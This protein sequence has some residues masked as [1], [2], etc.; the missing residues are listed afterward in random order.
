[1]PKI[2]LKQAAVDK[3]SCPMNKSKAD[4]FDTK[5]PGL[6]LKTLSS[7]KKT[8]YLRYRDIH[9]KTTERKIADA[10]VIKLADARELAQK[11]LTQIAMGEDPFKA[12][13]LL[14]DVPTVREFVEQSYMPYI[15]SYKRS[16]TT[17]W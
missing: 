10:T 6:L 9:N 1:L 12:Q 11:K 7:G 13:K 5:M 17:D 8:Y 15:K 3:L 16:W 2:L 4:Y 14:K